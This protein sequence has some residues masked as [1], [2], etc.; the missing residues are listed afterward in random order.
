SLKL[1]EKMRDLTQRTGQTEEAA[2]QCL[3][4]VQLYI[5]REDFDTAHER[6]LEARQLDARVNIAAGLEA[7]RRARRPDL[8]PTPAPASSA[9]RNPF[10]SPFRRTAIPTCCSTRCV[11]WTKRRCERCGRR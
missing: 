3:A 8:Q 5:D 10:P 7:I 4:L 9:P 11:S 6:L 2:R 1:R